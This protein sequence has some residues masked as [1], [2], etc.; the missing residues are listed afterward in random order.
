M[1]SP[2]LR[3]RGSPSRG[4]NGTRKSHPL[5]S[6]VEHRL[7]FVAE[8]NGVRYYNDSKA[9][10]VDATLKALDAF[11]GRILII[12]GGK[13]KGSNYTGSP[14]AA[15]RKKAI[16]ALLIGVRRAENRKPD[17]RQRRHRTCPARSTAPWKSP[18]RAAQPGDIVLAARACL[19]Q[20]RPI[21]KLRT[22][23]PR[24][25]AARPAV[26]GTNGPLGF[27]KKGER[28]QRRTESDRWRFGVTLGLC[29]LG[30]VMIYIAP[31]P[32]PPST[33]TGTPTYFILRQAVWLVLGIAEC[34]L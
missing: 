20:L 28:M 19:L 30:A 26:D 1:F 32:S 34:S 6:G 31:P 9:T 5:L 3:P 33:I 24:V 16:L 2:P 13:D 27:W 21:R 22:P 4:P 11:P 29:L 15:A 12:L 8:H 18:P 23:W 7:E 17:R 14:N 10:N 25:Q